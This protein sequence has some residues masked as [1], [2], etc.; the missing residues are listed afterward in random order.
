MLHLFNIFDVSEYCWNIWTYITTLFYF[1]AIHFEF[2]ECSE[3]FFP[4][5]CI[6]LLPSCLFLLFQCVVTRILSAL[7][8]CH[9]P[10]PLSSLLPLFILDWMLV[11]FSH[12]LLIACVNGSERC[13]CLNY[14]LNALEK[15]LNPH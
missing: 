11:F 6:L 7:S 8:N 4:N 1:F 13:C 5:F 9:R 3:V 2:V 10:R 14:T 12:R 15:S